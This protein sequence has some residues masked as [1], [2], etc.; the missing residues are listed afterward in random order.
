MKNKVPS[1]LYKYGSIAKPEYLREVLLENKIYCTSPFDFNDPFDCRPRIV[2]GKTQQE[3]RGAKKVIEG[4]LKKRTILDR[5]ARRVKAGRLIKQIQ[6][7][8]NLT[9][10]YKSLLSRAG[11]YC[12]SGKKDNLLMWAH[13]GDKH[14]GYCLEFCAE[15]EGSFFSGAE[16]VRYQRNY[17]VVKILAEDTLDW[18][19]ESFLIKSSDWAYEEEW[20][21][22]SKKPGHIDF[23]PETLASVI[24][25]C[26]LSDT[27]RE[28]IL[29]WNATRHP[30]I[31][32]YQAIMH[33][34]E[35]KL[36]INSV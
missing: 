35:Y 14:K 8:Q 5:N 11:V 22:T 15:P 24:L 33:Q 4:I 1:K 28:Q 19:K 7:F 6:K 26:R 36:Q 25:G 20:R 13:Y 16:E 12:L 3:L 27:H 2:I 9:D 31:K 29:E 32:I 34:G 21:L 18:G 23:P 30:S 17:P 10:V